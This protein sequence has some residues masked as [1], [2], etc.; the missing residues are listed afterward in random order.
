MLKVRALVASFNGT[1][2]SYSW[3]ADKEMS[4]F[5][6]GTFCQRRRQTLRF[7]YCPGAQATCV[8]RPV[9][10]ET[11][12][13]WRATEPIIRRMQGCYYKA[14]TSKNSWGFCHMIGAGKATQCSHLAALVLLYPTDKH[15]GHDWEGHGDQWSHTAAERRWVTHPDKQLRVA[16]VPTRVRQI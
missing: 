2:I 12:N 3:R 1:L 5:E 6:Q 15:S 7:G 16:W 10:K 9:D 14:G 4:L 13:L 11:N 8:E